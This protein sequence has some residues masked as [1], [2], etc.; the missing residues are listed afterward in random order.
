VVL[1]GGRATT[2]SGTSFA[3]ALAGAALTSL[4]ARCPLPATHLCA[5]LCRGTG[6]ATRTLPPDL[7]VWRAFQHLT[8]S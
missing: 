7:D 2:A 1:A 8:P 5:A 4:A 6:P 3:A